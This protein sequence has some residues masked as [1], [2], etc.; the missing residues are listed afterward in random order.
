MNQENQ[1]E[2][3]INY[4]EQL[5]E[6][7]RELELLKALEE[8][9]NNSM[10]PEIKPRYFGTVRLKKSQAALLYAAYQAKVKELESKVAGYEVTIS[11]VP[12]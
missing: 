1:T 12:K 7:N 3:T 6:A 5:I 9:F 11:A 10:D 8:D 4:K 2:S